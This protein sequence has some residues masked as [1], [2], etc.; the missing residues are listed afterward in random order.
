M[1]AAALSLKKR[2][3][4]VLEDSK[5]LS[6]ILRYC[7]ANWFRE[8]QV[9][10]FED[11]NLA[12]AELEQQAPDLLITDLQHP[13]MTGDNLIWRLAEKKVTFPILLLSGDFNGPLKLPPNLKVICL[14]KPFN[15]DNLWLVLNELVGPCDYS[16]FGLA[17]PSASAPVNQPAVVHTNFQT[18]QSKSTTSTPGTGSSVSNLSAR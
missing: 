8:A 18:D 10:L 12:W 1:S 17:T 5:L 3:I 4:V 7:I 9:S 14:S 2:R 6:E 13:G 15:R 16:V 11:G